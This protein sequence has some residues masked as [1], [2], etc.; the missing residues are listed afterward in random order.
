MPDGPLATDKAI[1]LQ[2]ARIEGIVSPV[3]GV[4]NVV[5]APDLDPDN[6]LAK[7]L[8]LL[9][10]ADA[11]GIVVGAG[12]P[13]VLTSRADGGT[14]RLASCARGSGGQGRAGGQHQGGGLGGGARP[15]CSAPASIAGRCGPS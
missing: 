7:R 11:A 6:M 2:A 12:V 15:P 14:S 8:R 4:A 5:I 10:G 1:D 13:M 3:A 9:A